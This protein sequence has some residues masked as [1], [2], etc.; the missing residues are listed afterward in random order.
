M[1][2]NPPI[3]Y[4]LVGLNINSIKLTESDKVCPYKDAKFLAFTFSLLSIPCVT[5]VLYTY[6]QLIH[7][8]KVQK[9]KGYRVFYSAIL[10]LR[11]SSTIQQRN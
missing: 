1:H 6:P 11:F 5:L 10:V 7:L 2:V 4:F 8:S 3:T 9:H